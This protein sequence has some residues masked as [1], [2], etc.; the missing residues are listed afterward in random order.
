MIK[1]YFKSLR[2]EAISEIE[3]PKPG[4]W[5]HVEAPNV[6]ELELLSERFK[7]EEGFIQDA[8]DE[9]EVPRLEREGGQTYIFVRYAYKTAE[10]DLDTARQLL[11][12]SLAIY[13]QALGT[14]HPTTQKVRADLARLDQLASDA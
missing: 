10:G 3:Q 5:V 4:T 14:D 13:V 9:D 12:R 2:T 1:Y 7:L 11:V 6:N 8:L